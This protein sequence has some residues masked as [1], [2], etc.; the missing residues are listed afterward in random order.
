M[1]DDESAVHVGIMLELDVRMK[2]R[3]RNGNVHG[4]QDVDLVVDCRATCNNL[5]VVSSKKP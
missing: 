1:C 5:G 4:E 3:A 2:V